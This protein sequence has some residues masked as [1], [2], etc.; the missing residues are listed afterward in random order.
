MIYRVAPTSRAG[1]ISRNSSQVNSKPTPSVPQSA[2][3]TLRGICSTYPGPGVVH[4]HG[5]R[6]HL[7]SRY[8]DSFGHKIFI[9]RP[10]R[11]EKGRKEDSH[12]DFML[13]GASKPSQERS[14]IQPQNSRFSSSAPPPGNALHQGMPYTSWMPE[15]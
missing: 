5:W 15:N 2:S 1:L 4:W 7:L 6:R 11:R 9:H 10:G 12:V 13:L 8:N 3:P 14:S